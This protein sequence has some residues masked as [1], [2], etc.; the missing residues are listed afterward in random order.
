MYADGNTKNEYEILNFLKDLDLPHVPSDFSS[1][2]MI[3]EDDVLDAIK[4]LNPG[5]SP[6]PDS[7]S[8]DFYLQF[9]PFLS[10]L[11]VELS[12]KFLKGSLPY[13]LA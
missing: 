1:P 3:T 2:K 12:I 8:P 9:A 10:D 13:S 11:L 4:K 6:S 5:K 7:F